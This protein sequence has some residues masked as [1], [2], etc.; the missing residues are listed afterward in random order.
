MSK[1]LPA[2]FNDF[3]CLFLMAMIFVI[4]ILDGLAII[5]FNP[6]ILGAT[7]AFFTLI[8]QYYYRRRPNEKPNGL[9]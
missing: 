4:W 6:E 8:G 9:L 2:N 7:I 3:L 1:F 5:S